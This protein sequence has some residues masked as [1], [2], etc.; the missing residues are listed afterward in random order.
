MVI[1]VESGDLCEPSDRDPTLSAL[2]LVRGHGLDARHE[3]IAGTSEVLE[4]GLAGQHEHG[5][6]VSG[7]EVV[8]DR[9]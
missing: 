2:Q 9:S 3:I 4:D 5:R 8:H 6:G 1:G 7:V